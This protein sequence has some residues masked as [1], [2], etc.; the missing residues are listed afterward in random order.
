MPDEMD[1][2]NMKKLL[3]LAPNNIL[4]VKREYEKLGVTS[5][6]HFLLHQYNKKFTLCDVSFIINSLQYVFT[7]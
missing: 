5:L 3:K 1:R 6:V 2:R 4:R 7:S